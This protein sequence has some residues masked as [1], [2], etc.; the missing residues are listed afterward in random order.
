MSPVISFSY[1]TEFSIIWPK[2]PYPT[3]KRYEAQVLQKGQIQSLDVGF[4]RNFP[5]SLTHGGL[6]HFRIRNRMPRPQVREQAFQS[7]HSLHDPS[8]GFFTTGPTFFFRLPIDSQKP[9]MHH[10]A[11]RKHRFNSCGRKK[12]FFFY[13][14]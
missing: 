2:H 8:R 6:S 1:E 13:G 10:C 7:L 14:P 9:L 11:R 3:T 4:V 5:K 12:K